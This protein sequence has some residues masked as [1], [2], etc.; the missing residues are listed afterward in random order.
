MAAD[1]VSLMKGLIL[2][3]FSLKTILNCSA[4]AVQVA[5]EPRSQSP[6]SD[7]VDHFSRLT[8]GK[9]QLILTNYWFRPLL[10]LPGHCGSSSLWDR[11]VGRYRVGHMIKGTGHVGNHFSSVWKI[12][13][14][15]SVSCANSKS[16]RKSLNGLRKTAL[17]VLLPIE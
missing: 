16:L 12:L 9:I 14:Q 5:T 15:V 1:Y 6:F 17:S 10:A 8:V 7:L 2:L 11:S 4:K 13:S 3:S